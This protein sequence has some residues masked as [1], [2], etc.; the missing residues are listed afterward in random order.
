[1]APRYLQSTKSEDKYEHD[2]FILKIILKPEE[3]KYY[4]LGH[5]VGILIPVTKLVFNS[6]YLMLQLKPISWLFSLSFHSQYKAHFLEDKSKA[7]KA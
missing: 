5:P 2:K 1:M 4:F 6:K 7:G 3:K